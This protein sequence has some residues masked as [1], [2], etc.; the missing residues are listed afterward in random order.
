MAQKNA[1]PTKEQKA[2]LER[3]GLK[4]MCWV[5]VKDLNTQLIVRHRI[6]GEFKLLDKKK[7]GVKS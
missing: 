6:T 4:P 1:T 7:E 3:N 2:E 5:V